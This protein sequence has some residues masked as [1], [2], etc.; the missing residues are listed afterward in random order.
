MNTREREYAT[1][2]F[3]EAKDRGA[4]EETFFPWDLTA[5]RLAGEG[6]PTEVVRPVLD[7]W[8]GELGIDGFMPS[9]P[10]EKYLLSAAY[11]SV[12]DYEKWLGFDAV[13]RVS[14]ALPLRGLE[15]QVLE[16]TPEHTLYRAENGRVIDLHKRSDVAINQTYSVTR[17][18]DWS[19]L[20]ELARR[21]EATH[22]A[23]EAFDSVYGPLQAGQASGEYSV[24]MN[25][26]G[27][28][29]TPRELLGTEGLSYA[30]YDA[31]ELIHRINRFALSVFKEQLPKA[32]AV[33][34][35][36]VLYVMEDLSGVNGPLISPR[37]FD[38]FVAP[39]YLEL[40]PM[41]RE[42]G[43]RHVFVDTDGD[44]RRLIPN[45]MSVGV[46]GFLPVDVNAGVDI[47]SVRQ[48]YPQVKFIGGFNKLCIAEGPEAIDQEFARLLPVIRQGGYLPGADHQVAPSTSLEDY[49]YYISRLEQ[50]MRQAGVDGTQDAY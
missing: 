32:L 14:F 2:S 49:R 17:P 19:D 7:A 34:P 1:L 31:P 26:E 8:A 13:R 6:M 37:M 50:V 16:D 35:A 39:Y 42:L 46:D 3:G 41:I 40:V 12:L 15:R 44:F 43:V 38:E 23:S 11:G 22:Y 30:F 27:F 45:F 36:D 20:E 25:I 33:L 4:V 28:F 48:D 9:C 29:W 24:R 10:P 18:E 5:E 47:V 21:E